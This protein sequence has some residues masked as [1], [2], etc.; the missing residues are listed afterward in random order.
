MD[1][2]AKLTEIESHLVAPWGIEQL[3]RDQLV[4]DI[5]YLIRRVKALEA[6]LEW[7]HKGQVARALAQMIDEATDPGGYPWTSHQSISRLSAD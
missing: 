5:T 7:E 2:T 6:S 3:D 4:E 1:H